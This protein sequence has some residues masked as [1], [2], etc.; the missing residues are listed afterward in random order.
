MGGGAEADISI[1]NIAS[2][3]SVK[4]TFDRKTLYM[5]RK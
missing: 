5:F 1:G 4:D 3:Q 2:Q